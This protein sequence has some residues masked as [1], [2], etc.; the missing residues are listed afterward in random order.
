MYWRDMAV[1]DDDDRGRDVLMFS[2]NGVG[3]MMPAAGQ[4][5]AWVSVL[6]SSLSGRFILALWV[7]ALQQ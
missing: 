2:V 3:K 7:V 6:I 5:E 1:G 4:E